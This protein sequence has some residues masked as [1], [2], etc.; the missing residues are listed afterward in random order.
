MVRRLKSLERSRRSPVLSRAAKARAVPSPA[1]D[2]APSQAQSA[3][4][5]RLDETATA[6]PEQTHPQSAVT[7]PAPHLPLHPPAHGPISTAGHAPTG[8]DWFA[9]WPFPSQLFCFSLV[10][11]AGMW[12]LDRQDQNPA[13]V[14]PASQALPAPKPRPPLPPETFDW[15]NRL[16]ETQVI[17]DQL[18]AEFA[19]AQQFYREYALD[20]FLD[21]DPWALGTDEVLTLT[22]FCE[23]GFFTVERE[24]LVKILERKVIDQPPHSPSEP[25]GATAR[26]AAAAE[27]RES[28]LASLREAAD[29]YRRGRSAEVT[30]PVNLS[31]EE[32]QARR[33]ALVDKLATVRRERDRLDARIAEL[34]ALL[35]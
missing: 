24:I 5:D 26:L 15:L 30:L 21:F 3:I 27:D 8:W 25:R 22:H 33:A 20:E 28:R 7:L 19:E 1:Q 6:A 9:Q 18:E 16:R 17:T 12:W 2:T 13:P 35:R 10:M 31:P 32:D 11:A 4:P 34:N 14:A 23:Q 29:L